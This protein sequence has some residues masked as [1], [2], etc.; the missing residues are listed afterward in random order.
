MELEKIWKDLVS[1]GIHPSLGTSQARRVMLTNQI[2]LIATIVMIPLIMLFG[3]V[4]PLPITIG[5]IF[6]VP[7]FISSIYLNSKRRYIFSKYILIFTITISVF[8]SG[9]MYGKHSISQVIFIPT[10]IGLAYIFDFQNRRHFFLAAL[11]PLSGLITLDLTDYSLFL[12]DDLTPEIVTQIYYS[13]FTVTIF[14]SLLII[15]FYKRSMEDHAAEI[16]KT[17]AQLRTVFE[18]SIDAVFLINVEDFII[19]D[20]NHRAKEMMGGET[21]EAI[22]GR[23]IFTFICADEGNEALIAEIKENLKA[24]KSWEREIETTCLRNGF[25]W[26]HWGFSALPHNENNLGIVRVTNIQPQ[27]ETEQ[28][29]IESKSVLLEAQRMAKM[30]NSVIDFIE[31][32]AYWSAELFNIF[33]VEKDFIPNYDNFC[34]ILHPDDVHIFQKAIYKSLTYQ[35]DLDIIYRAIRPV[36]QELIYLQSRGELILNEKGESIKMRTIVQ[37]VT[38]QQKTK[39]Q[40]AF[41]KRQAEE[42]N[43]AKSYFL[44]SMSH[45]IRTPLNGILGFTNLLLQSPLTEEQEHHLELIHSSGDTLLRLLS[46]ILDFNKIEEG[47]L[48]L[49][50]VDFNFRETVQACLEPYEHQAK[51]KG[52]YLNLAIEEEVPTFVESD[53]TRLKQIIVNLVSNSL[54]FT[55]KGGIRINCGLNGANGV[56]SNKRMLKI[57]VYDTGIGIPIDKQEEIF[58][59]FSQADSSTTRKYGGSGLGLSILKELSLMMGGDVKVVSPVNPGANNPGALF[60]VTLLVGVGDKGGV[61]PSP[62]A[63][64]SQYFREGQPPVILLVEDNPVNQILSKKLLV[65]MGAKV[66]VVENGEKAARFFEKEHIPV[67]LILMDIQ[68]PVMDGYD[69]TRAIRPQNPHIPIIALSANAYVEDIERSQEAGMNDYLSKPFKPEELFAVINKWLVPA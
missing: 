39:H 57:D 61:K 47:K 15:W 55:E 26:G 67:D 62:T 19:Q 40:L 44:T 59:V 42:A 69:A 51:I 65:K 28:R 3:N 29:L 17:E 46:D 43:R 53:P 50:E 52:L 38:L 34:H 60:S 54:K 66:I 4:S 13:S 5:Y 36:D 68:M 14:S 7:L 23:S 49:E 1:K 10:L 30:G 48:S 9:S 22:I 27:K 58:Q 6:S 11:I 25:F 37:D 21:K 35:V 41:A 33:G 24:S 56:A 12:L 32:R 16:E 18:H 63:E 2:S 45:E 64:S 20:C 31:K 8:M